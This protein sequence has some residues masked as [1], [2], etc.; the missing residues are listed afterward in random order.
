MNTDKRQLLHFTWGE[1]K[2]CIPKSCRREE[3]KVFLG[4]PEVLG[5]QNKGHYSQ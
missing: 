1:E 2:G 3:L 4:Y 5:S